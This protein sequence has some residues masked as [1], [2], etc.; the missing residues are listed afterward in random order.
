[1]LLEPVVLLRRAAAPM[2][3]FVLML[4]LPCHIV[5]PLIVAS[6]VVTRFPEVPER[7]NPSILFLLNIRSWLSVVPIN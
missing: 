4:P 3:V 1:M 6:A 7:R 5:N 2:A